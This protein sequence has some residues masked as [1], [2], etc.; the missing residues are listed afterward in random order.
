M[1]LLDIPSRQSRH[2][3]SFKLYTLR[4]YG[5]ISS[6]CI[7]RFFR[8]FSSILYG[9]LAP[10][11]RR[12]IMTNVGPLL[13]SGLAAGPS[14]EG[15]SAA[16]VSVRFSSLRAGVA[17]DDDAAGCALS[18]GLISPMFVN[19]TGAIWGAPEAVAVEVV[20][21]GAPVGD[22]SVS[23]STA[24]EDSASWA[25]EVCGADAFAWGIFCAVVDGW[26]SEGVVMVGPNDPALRNVIGDKDGKTTPSERGVARRRVVMYTTCEGVYY[27]CSERGGG[28]AV[29]QV[30]S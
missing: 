23:I 4:L 5:F 7:L 15:P 21:A 13:L 10:V 22:W 30:R 8:Y 29:L 2:I 20:G 24:L 26:S 18:D 28:A 14:V 12:S 16:S 11:V 3:N 9:C 6:T 25:G 27:C 19:S 17:V 1:D